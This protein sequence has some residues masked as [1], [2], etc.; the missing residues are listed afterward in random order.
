MR[1]LL[2]T[3]VFL[4]PILAVTGCGIV[5]KQDIQQGNLLEKKNVEQLKP[6]MTKRQVVVLLGSPS[7]ASPFDHDRWDYLSTFSR[8]GGKMTQRTLT[9]YFNN[10]VLV[11]TEG[12]YFPQDASKLLE[13]TSKYKMKY[14]VDENEKHA[15]DD[16]D[17]N[18]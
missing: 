5:Y 12:N 10:D 17:D 1:T 15:S 3:L 9:L 8:R 14:S 11:R 7:I 16:S 4:L 18:Q 13:Q 2:R 6:G